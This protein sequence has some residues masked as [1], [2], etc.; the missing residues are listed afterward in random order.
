[1]PM[2]AAGAVESTETGRCMAG[3][4]ALSPGSLVVM[5]I[6]PEAHTPAG[7]PLA[8]AVTVSCWFAP[9]ARLKD[10]DETLSFRPEVRPLTVTLYVG[11]ALVNALVNVRVQL[12][13][14]TH[15]ALA[16]P[17]KLSVARSP[18]LSGLALV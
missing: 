16:S 12:Q 7:T 15:P 5:S 9:G 1:M 8:S 11:L 6:S 4:A 14:V 18:P 17:G 10:V 2:C 3:I 13:L